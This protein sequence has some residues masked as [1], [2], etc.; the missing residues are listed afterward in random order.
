MV[1]VSYSGKEINAKLVYYGPGLSGKTTNLEYIYGS[2]PGTHRGKMVS[3]KTKTE[4]T[5]FFDFLP[6]QLG[7]LSGFKT[8]FLLY[9]VPGQV[10]YNA[11]R[12]LVLKGVD[13][14]VFVADSKRGKMD[15]NV[16]SLQ[17]L[18]ENLLEHGHKLEDIPFVLQYNKRDLPEVYS[19]SEL[20]QVLNPMHVPVFEAVATSG[21]GVVETFKAVSKLLLK[22]LAEEIGVPIVGAGKS[23]GIDLATQGQAAAQPQPSRPAAPE[24]IQVATPAPPPPIPAAPPAQSIPL[25]PAAPTQSIPLAPAQSIPSVPAQPQPAAHP[26]GNPPAASAHTQLPP[27]PT[28]HTPAASTGHAQTP[29]APPHQHSIPAAS[30]EQAQSPTPPPPQP[31]L[32]SQ[33]APSNQAILRTPSAPTSRPGGAFAD[34]HASG[35]GVWAKSGDDAGESDLRV[36]H[37]QV[38]Y[39]SPRNAEP[40]ES[41]S[42]SFTGSLGSPVHGSP[43]RA[44]LAEARET[45]ESRNT[46]VAARLRKWLK[47]EEPAETAIQGSGVPT[48]G[49]GA[50]GSGE[51]GATGEG[52]PLPLHG[53]PADPADSRPPIGAGPEL[54][55]AIAQA[56]DSAPSRTTELAQAETGWRTDPG[57]SVSDRSS[58]R[59]SDR[60]D[61][62]RVQEDL[63]PVRE[64]GPVRAREITVPLELTPADLESGIIIRL[65][66]RLQE[67]DEEDRIGRRA[68]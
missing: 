22:K 14:V 61:E 51:H 54:R 20:D 29:A 58:E 41:A 44:P 37:H 42:A 65:A 32:G 53:E 21:P 4:R 66:V 24:V 7:E 9:T 13:A 10:Y 39:D 18:R 17:N 6:V 68:A 50:H 57:L 55:T 15:E 45:E 11:T 3:M 48:S 2:I 34:A 38:S 63:A 1:L 12:K 19:V 31:I 62:R 60:R 47:R 64:R 23:E 40:Q 16:E 26:H 56:F 46:G 33:P 49:A 30:I 35:R 8:R 59:M 28:G 67:S 25:A 27:I 52:E 36:E 5:L 43:A